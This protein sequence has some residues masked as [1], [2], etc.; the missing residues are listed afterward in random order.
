MLDEVGEFDFGELTDLGGEG[1]D[2]GDG[3][4]LAISIKNE[5]DGDAVIELGAIPGAQKGNVLTAGGNVQGNEML[6]QRVAELGMGSD[7]PIELL[8]GGAV[9]L[10]ELDPEVSAGAFG[11]FKRGGV[12]FAGV[13]LW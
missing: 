13:N 12:N 5:D 8:A 10:A 11:C 1:F 7:E 3:E 6:M 9:G 2:R 4:H